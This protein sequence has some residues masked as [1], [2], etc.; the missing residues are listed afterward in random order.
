MNK[1]AV[2]SILNEIESEL[3]AIIKKENVLLL[4]T[5]QQFTCDIVGN[6]K[7]LRIDVINDIKQNA[8]E[9]YL[10]VIERQSQIINH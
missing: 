5:I 10:A 9:I 6:V 3:N 4:D 2:L 7:D 8:P 1:K